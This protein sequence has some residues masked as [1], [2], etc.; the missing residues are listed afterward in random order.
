MELATVSWE[1]Q[2]SLYSLWILSPDWAWNIQ[3]A[4]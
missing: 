4:V 2:C 3:S 1:S